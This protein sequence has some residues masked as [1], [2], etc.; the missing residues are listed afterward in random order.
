MVRQRDESAR[1][2]DDARI[3]LAEIDEVRARGVPLFLAPVALDALQDALRRYLA[4]PE[5]T[6]PG[7]L[8]AMEDLLHA[9]EEWRVHATGT[10]ALAGARART[11]DLLRRLREE[12]IF[13][14]RANGNAPQGA[15]RSFLNGAQGGTLPAVPDETETPRNRRRRRSSAR[16][17]P[18]SARPLR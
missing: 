2:N 18:G 4:A 3:L 16:T 6:D 11:T 10:D 9:A 8:R 1:P 17:S 12:V 15:S 5:L 13:T 14:Q 7:E